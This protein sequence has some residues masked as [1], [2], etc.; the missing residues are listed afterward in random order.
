MR[1]LAALLVLL[2]LA[3]FS[4]CGS[5]SSSSSSAGGLA[6]AVPA[7]HIHF[8]KT[9]FLLHAGLAF[10]AF[11]RYVY[12]PL[13]EGDFSHPLAHKLALVKA[14]AAVAFIVH[15]LR[16]AREDA[17]ASAVLRRLFSPLGALAGSVGA[18]AAGLRAGHPSGTAVSSA[19]GAIDSIKSLASS[20][21]A[22]VTEH[23][24]ALT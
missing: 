4:G 16:I 12:R 22:P 15:E 11:H 2:A 3:F 24:P 6:A 18:L 8:A 23:T 1:L 10:G 9:K 19:N 7:K 14:A 20:A 17:Q 13:Q 5:K 21:G